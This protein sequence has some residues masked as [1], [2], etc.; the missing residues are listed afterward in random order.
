MS[1]WRSDIVRTFHASDAAHDE[2]DRAAVLERSPPIVSTGGPV[3]IYSAGP[4]WLRVL[5][6][7]G[8]AVLFVVLA[9]NYY[10]HFWRRR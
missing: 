10:T 1:A 8:A 2:E 4:L 9:W 7:I 6:A 5:I 3:I